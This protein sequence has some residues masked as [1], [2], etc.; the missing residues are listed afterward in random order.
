MPQ[1]ALGDL[2]PSIH[3]KAF[4]HPEATLIGDVIV[5]AGGSVWPGT[6]L[7]GDYGRIEVRE[8]SSVQDGTVVH[9]GP[10]FPT[11]I[12][13]FALVGHNAHLEGCTV[14]PWALVGSM[15]VVLHYC[16]VRSH[17]IVGAGAVVPDN[18]EVPSGCMAL[19]VPCQIVPDRV[20]LFANREPVEH[21]IANA[22][23]YLEQL[24]LIE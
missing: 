18:T 4:V 24:Q 17:S 2:R 23:R 22:A 16:I 13:P 6:V 7:R 12:G 1:Y 21:Y 11:L 19:G 5:E 9:A 20:R 3:P 14:E 15:S 8:G 10:D